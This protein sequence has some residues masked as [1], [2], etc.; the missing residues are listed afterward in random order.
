MTGP[1]LIIGFGA[2]GASAARLLLSTGLPAERLVV[3]DQRRTAV[4]EAA[5]LGARTVLGDAADRSALRRTGI[6][7]ARHVIVAVQPDATAVFIT[8]V[9]REMCAPD[10][11]V[12]TA[13]TDRK[14]VAHLRGAD[15]VVISS[16]TAGAALAAGALGQ[17]LAPAQ[18]P[19]SGWLVQSR[20]V[21]SS[22][23][24]LFLRECGASAIGVLRGGVR[25][26]GAAAA[27]LR[28]AAGDRIMI[29]CR[30]GVVPGPPG[31]P[32]T[33]ATSPVPR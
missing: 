30:G 3:I 22:E 26:L 20:P 16:D 27:S 1:T 10:A 11:V 21:Q 32:G 17:R 18:Q 12:V 4:T 14:H 8:M 24:G 23:I 7:G 28:L 6:A 13:V 19:G 29:M 15:Q 31:D 9:A 25:H 33:P 5:D 2:I